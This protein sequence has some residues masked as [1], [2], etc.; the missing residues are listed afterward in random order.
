MGV[1]VLDHLQPVLLQDLGLG[2]RL[3]RRSLG[4]VGKHL[5]CFIAA[6]DDTAEWLVIHYKGY[7]G[8]VDELKA[9]VPNSRRINT[10][11]W[12]RHHGTN[13]FADVHNVIV[14]GQLTYRP[15]D[16]QALAC[17]AS[18]LPA[19]TVEAKI[20]LENLRWGEFQH[21]LLQALCRASV[22][23]SQNGIAGACRAW[24]IS[25]PSA[26]TEQRVRDTFPGCRL[27][28]WEPLTPKV[29]ERVRQAIAFIQQRRTEGAVEIRKAELRTHLGM[30]VNN[31]RRDVVALPAFQNA[32]KDAE[33]WET[34]QTFGPKPSFGADQ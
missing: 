12:G 21:H 22:R 4:D 15:I 14:I 25:T 27:F 8:I 9:L 19:A 17:A 33:L 16:Y 26:Q 29:S 32:L 6:E 2:N 20:D 30:S 13:I 23:R 24:V 1:D 11:T 5:R 10:L 18:G 3:G 7:G 28:D 31:F 34:T